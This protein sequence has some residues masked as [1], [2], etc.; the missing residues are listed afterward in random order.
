MMLR[1]KTGL[2]ICLILISY[3]LW[4]GIVFSFFSHNVY[5]LISLIILTLI[6]AALL[7]VW[8]NKVVFKRLKKLNKNINKTIATQEFTSRLYEAG[9][10]EITS[11]AK[12]FN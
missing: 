3:L 9:T 12:L 1:T 8:L 11:L 10:D 6:S 2:G 5:F 7:I 4:V